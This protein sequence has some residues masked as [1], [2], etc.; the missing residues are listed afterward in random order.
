MFRSLEARPLAVQQHSGRGSSYPDLLGSALLPE[1]DHVGDQ[2]V[3]LFALLRA[4]VGLPVDDARWWPARPPRQARRANWFAASD[5]AAPA[6]AGTSSP[7][8][9]SIGDLVVPVVA[10]AP[11]TPELLERTLAGL[12]AWAGT[13]DGE[14]S[15]RHAR[16]A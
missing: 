13:S 15:Q 16:R 1:K 10:I 5:D 12:L 7:A 14:E 9:W 4:T 3:P 2:D 8:C 6:G 11:P